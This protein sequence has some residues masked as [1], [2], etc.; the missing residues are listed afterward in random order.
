MTEKSKEVVIIILSCRHSREYFIRI[1][2]AL[3]W[4]AE[5]NN[6]LPIFVFTG[7]DPIPPNRISTVYN[8]KR[9]IWEDKS[10][11]TEENVVNTLEIL[12]KN[13]ILDLPRVWVTFWYH[14]PKIKLF[15]R[16]NG[17][18]VKRETFIKSYSGIQ[19]INILV[20]LFAL[21]EAYFNL[22][23]KPFILAIK[24]ILGYNV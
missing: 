16:R 14:P 9:I 18:D 19:L 15:L 4:F 1:E 8:R 5:N 3:K 2:T 11:N 21:L 7:K 6:V 24:R 12:K 22:N 10:V 17:V 20:E 13:W 23:R